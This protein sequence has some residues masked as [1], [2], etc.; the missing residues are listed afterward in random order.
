MLRIFVWSPQNTWSTMM[1]QAKP[2]TTQDLCAAEILVLL[3]PGVEAREVFKTALKE[4]LA[5]KPIWL[6]KRQVRSFLGMR[7][8]KTH[9]PLGAGQPPKNPIPLNLTSYLRTELRHIDDLSCAQIRCT[10]GSST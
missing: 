9:L 7:S 1:T 10:N 3:N 5:L 6:E 4:L 8:K 2:M